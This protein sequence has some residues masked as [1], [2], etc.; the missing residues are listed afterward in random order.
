MG[1]Y[2]I[3]VVMILTVLI[4]GIENGADKVAER[5]MLG[6]NLIRGTIIYAIT[7]FTI[8]LLFNIIA[9]SIITGIAQP[10]M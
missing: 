9:A 8:T 4:N 5:F 6:T 2:I 7:A 1:I 10:G 3:Q